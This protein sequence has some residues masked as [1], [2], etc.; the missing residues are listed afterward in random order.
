MHKLARVT[1]QVITTAV[2]LVLGIATVARAGS[3]VPEINPTD[4]MSALALIGG[5][6]LLIRGMRKK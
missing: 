2:L 6:V 1:M 4:G 5:A 3:A